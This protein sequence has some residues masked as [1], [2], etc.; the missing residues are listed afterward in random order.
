MAINPDL[1]SVNCIALSLS[2]VVPQLQG[3]LALDARHHTP[4][5][6]AVKRELPGLSD[7]PA[8]R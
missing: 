4:G 2:L 5:K 7:E 3:H 1:G 8:R 6:A